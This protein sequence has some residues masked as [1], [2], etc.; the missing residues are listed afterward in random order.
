[1]AFREQAQQLRTDEGDVT[2]A[3][4]Q[5]EIAGADE[6]GD[7]RGGLRPGRD[8]VGLGATADPVGHQG[9]ADA[10]HG[11]LPCGVD[12]HDDDHVGG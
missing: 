4:G 11:V 1:V 8:V 7:R 5:D 9:A 3:D 12:V 2:G 10:G 6:A